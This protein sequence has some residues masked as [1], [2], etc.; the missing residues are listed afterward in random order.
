MRHTGLKKK[1]EGDAQ[2]GPVQQSKWASEKENKEGREIINA[3]AP[4]MPDRLEL[5][6]VTA[7]F[8]GC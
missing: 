8:G 6:E 7:V 5:S 4:Q 2:K 3:N 1:T